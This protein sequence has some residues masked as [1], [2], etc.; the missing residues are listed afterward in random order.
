MVSQTSIYPTSKSGLETRTFLD[1]VLADDQ[2]CQIL[3]FE[4]KMCTSAKPRLIH[5]LEQRVAHSFGH[6]FNL[7]LLPNC[8]IDSSGWGESTLQP[9]KII[10]PH[11]SLFYI[12]WFLYNI[13]IT[14]LLINIHLNWLNNTNRPQ[15]LSTNKVTV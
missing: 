4:P 1:S 7:I 2:I 6:F 11:R 10:L 12:F 8:G 9:Q 13:I 14:Y 3:C 15:R 5:S